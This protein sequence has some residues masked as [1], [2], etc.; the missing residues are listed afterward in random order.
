MKANPILEEVW[1]IKD[2]LAAEAGY[3]VDRF[4]ENLRKWEAEHSPTG[5]VVRNAEE[6]RQLVAQKE[7][8]RA[9]QAAMALN[10]KPPRRKHGRGSKLP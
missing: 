10:S 9:E 4:F 5:P 7:R 2:Q 1:R 8:E 3:D 6:L